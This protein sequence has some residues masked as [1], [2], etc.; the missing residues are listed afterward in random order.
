MRLR[1]KTVRS[2]V[3]LGVGCLAIGSLGWGKSGDPGAATIRKVGVVTRGN[4]FELEI[5]SSQPVTPQTQ[6]ITGPDRLVIDFPNA[7]PGPALHALIVKALHVKSVRMSLFTAN[8]PVARVV[9][10]LDSPQSYEV[11]PSGKSIIVKISGDAHPSSA[12]LHSA[13]ASAATPASAPASPAPAEAASVPAPAPP[14]PPKPPPVLVEFAD[15]K[16]SV[17]TDHGMLGEVLR[18]IGQKT[19]ASVS[20]PPQAE[21]D[22]VIA[23]LGPASP[24]EVISALLSGVPYNIILMGSGRDLSQITSIVLTARGA[25]SGNAAPANFTPARAEEAPPEPDAAPPPPVEETPPQPDV[26]PPPPQ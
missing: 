7:V 6:V 23:H 20:V 15:G 1:F 12:S 8:P 14:E 21:Q 5:E 22:P 16:L 17:S 19:G 3:I 10:D 2:C 4:N 25:G 9:V 13:P 26:V 24:R 11:F 18:D